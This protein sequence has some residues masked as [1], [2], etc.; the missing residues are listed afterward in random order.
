[1]INFYA[2]SVSPCRSAHQMIAIDIFNDFL[3]GER[4]TGVVDTAELYFNTIGISC[5]RRSGSQKHAAQ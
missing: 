5:S 1:M 3:A 2:Q 4:Y